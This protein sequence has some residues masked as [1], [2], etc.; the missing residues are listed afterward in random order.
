MVFRL[1]GAPIE[2]PASSS[3]KRGRQYFAKAESS[4]QSTTIEIGQA[5][6][7]RN[8][9]SR[10]H[11]YIGIAE[12]FWRSKGKEF[13]SVL[14]LYEVH[15]ITPPLP[16]GVKSSELFFQSSHRDRNELETVIGPCSLVL[17]TVD[18]AYVHTNDVVRGRKK[19][20]VYWQFHPEDSPPAH[21]SRF[22]LSTFPFREMYITRAELSLRKEPQN[23]LNSLRVTLPSEAQSESGAIR[24]R[25]WL[26]PKASPT[27]SKLW[28]P[29]SEGVS[30]AVVLSNFQRSSEEMRAI[31]PP[32]QIDV[33]P[34][35]PR[36]CK[37][38]FNHAKN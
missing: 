21:L 36:D 33:P 16:P 24:S 38:C 11:P 8:P 2:N 31:V 25:Q 26:S 17:H 22:V 10:K 4:N 29:K 32:L 6:L 12:E 37:C 34:P 35:K 18:D 23:A 1:V 9:S 30:F 20:R 15:D 13:V 7:L 5:I 14:W 28:T 27:S 3:A 19:R